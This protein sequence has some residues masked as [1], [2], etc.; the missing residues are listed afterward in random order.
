MNTLTGRTARRQNLGKIG[1]FGLTV[2][3]GF[4]FSIFG[5]G[6]VPWFRSVHPVILIFYHFVC[7]IIISLFIVPLKTKS[8]GLVIMKAWDLVALELFLKIQVYLVLTIQVW[9]DFFVL[10]TLDFMWSYSCKWSSVIW[11]GRK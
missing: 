1:H 8:F 11:S 10:K 2:C 5:F 4:C 6:R 3:C 9:C 7:R